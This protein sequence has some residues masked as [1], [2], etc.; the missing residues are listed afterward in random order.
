M[1][2][3][4]SDKR[5]ITGGHVPAMEALHAPMAH[6]HRASSGHVGAVR[7]G[8]RIQINGGSDA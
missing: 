1:F 8:P 5:L 3:L 6:G 7:A 4:H 2:D